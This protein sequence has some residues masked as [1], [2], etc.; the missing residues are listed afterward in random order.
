MPFM[1]DEVAKGPSISGET[2]K[3]LH[4]VCAPGG[5]A[6]SVYMFLRYTLAQLSDPKISDVKMTML[7]REKKG[8]TIDAEEWWNLWS[9]DENLSEKL[10]APKGWSPEFVQKM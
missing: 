6:F 1:E 8:E 9:T 3:S 2:P 10:G 4:V 7:C 5:G